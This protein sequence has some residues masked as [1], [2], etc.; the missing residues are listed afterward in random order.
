M[1]I[2]DLSAC[3]YY[4]CVSKYSLAVLCQVV[5]G[6]MMQKYSITCTRFD[7]RTTQIGR[8]RPSSVAVHKCCS[9]FRLVLPRA[10]FCVSNHRVNLLCHSS[11]QSSF[12]ESEVCFGATSA[13]GTRVAFHVCV[14][15]L[16]LAREWQGEDYDILRCNCCHFSNELLRRGLRPLISWLA[17]DSRIARLTGGHLSGC[18]VGIG[19]AK[20]E[21]AHPL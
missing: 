17:L 18:D 7:R 8:R 4:C 21:L 10:T 3:R 12:S 19:V 14:W 6:S 5:Y 13:Q 11:R 2:V 16:R 20:L 15:L 1:C 9:H